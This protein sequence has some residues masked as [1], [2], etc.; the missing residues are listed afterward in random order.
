MWDDRS[1]CSLWVCLRHSPFRCWEVRDAGMSLGAAWGKWSTWLHSSTKY[2]IR[3]KHAQTTSSKLLMFVHFQGMEDILAVAPKTPLAQKRLCWCDSRVCLCLLDSGKTVWILFKGPSCGRMNSCIFW[4]CHYYFV[5]MA[6]QALESQVLSWFYVMVLTQVAVV[7]SI[8]IPKSVWAQGSSNSGG[9]WNIFTSSHL[10]IFSSSHLLILPYLPI[11]SSSHPHIF[12]SSHLFIFTS[13]CPHIHTSSNL[14]IFTSSHL[15]IF[16]SSHPHILA[17]SHLHIFSSSHLSSSQIFPS[18]HLHILTSSHLDILKSSS[19]HIFSSSHPHIF[20]SSH[21]HILTS[22][23]LLLLS[24]CP[25]AFSFFSI[26]LLKARGSANET[27]RTSGPAQPFRTKWGSIAKKC[28]K[29]AISSGPAQPFR[30]KWSSIA[31]N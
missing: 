23:H 5:L 9:L 26:S 28:G 24:S 3:Q 19:P 6:A 25:L 10:H 7:F 29:I 8:F 17:S 13:S 14:L 11:F 4:R 22:S 15:H 18:S 16:S 20:T 1:C 2:G 30:T 27:A 31:R 21:L 12:T